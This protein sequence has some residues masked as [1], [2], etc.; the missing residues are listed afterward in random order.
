[1]SRRVPRPGVGA[2][3]TPI[4][5]ALSTAAGVVVLG[6]L[7]ISGRRVLSR[8][9]VPRSAAGGSSVVAAGDVRDADWIYGD[10]AALERRARRTRSQSDEANQ[11]MHE[12]SQTVSEAEAIVRDAELKAVEILARA[13]KDRES[14]LE[15]T[16]VSAERTVLKLKEKA[17]REAAAIVKNAEVKAGDA[18]VGVE[19]ARARLEQEMQEVAREQARMAAKHEKLSEFLLTALE[20]IERAS[21]NG[22]ANVDGLQELRDELQKTD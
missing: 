21:A 20:E 19:R 10:R 8:T 15:Q 6:W 16:R 18:L 4:L 14:L 11:E 5:V 2:V 22:S 7:L 1:V 3:V 12:P 13:Q 9:R 17:E